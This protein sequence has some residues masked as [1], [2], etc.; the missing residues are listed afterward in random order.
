MNERAGF[1]FLHRR[2]I[3][4]RVFQSEGLLKVFIWC[5]LKSNHDEAWVPITTGRG[6]TEVRLKPG[7]FIFGRKTAAKELKMNPNTVYKRI[8][9]LQQLFI[10]SVKSN[11]HYSIITIMN[12]DTYQTQKNKSNNQVST[13]YQ[14]SNTNN[15]DNNDN[16]KRTPDFF[17][18]KKRYAHEE[19]IEDVFQAIAST[20][21]SGKV[22][23]SV[24]IAQLQI[25]ERYPVEQVE[26]AIKIYLDKDY[27]SQGKREA[28]LLGIIRNGNCQQTGKS[29][30]ECKTPEWL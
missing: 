12:W 3:D 24:L 17:S 14:P 21:K 13:K 4:S 8:Q 20:R 5:L 10:I 2:L 7:Q 25:W 6:T 15:N 29:K 9:K 30:P 19:L 18:L 23:D 22:A 11:T 27:A 1:I 16:K 28:Y 26:A